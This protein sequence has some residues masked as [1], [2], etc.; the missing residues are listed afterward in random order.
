MTTKSLFIHPRRVAPLVLGIAGLAG[1]STNHVGNTSAATAGDLAAGEAPRTEFDARLNAACGSGEMTA[2]GAAEFLRA[3]YVQNV[4]VDRAEVLWTT[5]A[6]GATEVRIT[7]PAGAEVAVVSAQVDE[8]ATLSKGD[9]YVA[10]VTGLEQGQIYCYEVVGEDGAWTTRLGFI[11]APASGPVR[12][13]AMGDMGGGTSDQY[14]VA[15]QIRTVEFDFALLTGDIAYPSGT[16]AQLEDYVFGIYTDIMEHVPFYAALGNHDYKT[17]NAQPLLSSFAL[18]DNAGAGERWYSFD[19]GDVHVAAIDTQRM[20]PAQVDWLD[21]DLAATDRPWKIVIGH[22]P[23]YSS[24]SHGNNMAVRDT[25]API[26][27][28]H[29]VALTLWGHDHDYEKTVDL[30]GVRYIVTGGGGRGTRPV[31]SSSFTEF[32]LQ[33]AHFLYVEVEGNSLTVYAIDGEGAVFD[34]LSLTR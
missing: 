22:H 14:A 11:T 5:D 20:D 8:S 17:N 21:R 18:P 15:D 2:T 30:N 12:F 3:P 31:G 26:F 6:A 4:D 25:F 13:I 1:C 7:D 34:T 24:G 19:W 33:V 27:E 16:L 28:K 9:Q 29:D 23:P 32:S 10:Q